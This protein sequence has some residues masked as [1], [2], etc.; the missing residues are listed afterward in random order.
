[1]KF[2]DFV[3][4]D[5]IR[6]ELSADDKE[7]VIRELVSALVES[8]RVAESDLEDIVKAIIKREELGSTA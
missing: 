6:A 2:S 1:M 8:G 4:Q 5:A 7:S 3:C